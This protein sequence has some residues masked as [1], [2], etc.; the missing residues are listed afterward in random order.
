MHGKGP[1]NRRQ[2]QTS[3]QP[4]AP[5]QTVKTKRAEEA[6]SRAIALA[7]LPATARASTDRE[8]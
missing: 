7:Q 4:N 2:R 1:K 8:R 5:L 3:G 6:A